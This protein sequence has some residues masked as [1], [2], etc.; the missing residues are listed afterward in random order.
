VRQFIFD[1]PAALHH[2]FHVLQ[3]GD[4]RGV[5]IVA[6]SAGA[7]DCANARLEINAPARPASAQ[8]IGANTP[9]AMFIFWRR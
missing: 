3:E 1:H 5:L 9:G 8:F 7:G 2:E 4:V 6:S